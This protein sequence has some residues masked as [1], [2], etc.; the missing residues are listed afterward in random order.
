MEN[1]HAK[2][3]MRLWHCSCRRSSAAD[4]FIW[5]D[6]QS[7]QLASRHRCLQAS[8]ARKINRAC[9]CT[10]QISSSTLCIGGMDKPALSNMSLLKGHS[11]V[12]W[13]IL[14]IQNHTS[15]VVGCKVEAEKHKIAVAG[16]R[17]LVTKLQK[18]RGNT[19]SL[20]QTCRRYAPMCQVYERRNTLCHNPRMSTTSTCF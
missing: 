8:S 13:N 2:M 16:Q 9:C 17:I 20:M 12:N 10:F 4:L 11:E 3:V 5:R 7:A 1:H 15:V 18:A 6:C 19:K 14:G